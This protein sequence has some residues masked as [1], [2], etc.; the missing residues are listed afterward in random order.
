[1]SSGVFE[2][3]QSIAADLFAVPATKLSSESA[4]DTVDAW[5]SAQHLTLVL[6]L[7]EQFGF[8]LTPEEIEEMR[9]LGEVVRIV[10]AKLRATKS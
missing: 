3:V 5:D 6:A 1:M 2:Q 9:N 10:E 7:E 8:Q 4:P